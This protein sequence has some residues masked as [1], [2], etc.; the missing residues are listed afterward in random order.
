[1]TFQDNLDFCKSEILI[2]T[3]DWFKTCKPDRDEYAGY[4]MWREHVI[5]HFS[6]FELEECKQGLSRM[7]QLYESIV[8]GKVIQEELL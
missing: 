4:Q 1:M 7:R 2:L 8:K 5:K 6:K 3:D